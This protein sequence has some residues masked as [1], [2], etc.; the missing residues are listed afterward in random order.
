MKQ[1][2]TKSSILKLSEAK[3]AVR[4]RKGSAKLTGVK[5]YTTWQS[6]ASNAVA[7]ATTSANNRLCLLEELTFGRDGKISE[8]KT[9]A[10]QGR[11]QT[12]KAGAHK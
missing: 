7:I 3:G 11:P 10:T 8:K 12:S 6:S 9:A 5:V 2:R 4:M 1:T